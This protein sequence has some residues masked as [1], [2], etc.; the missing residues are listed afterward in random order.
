MPEFVVAEELT[1]TGSM[2]META[3]LFGDP[4]VF[5]QLEIRQSL[6]RIPEVS[7]KIREAQSF[8][9]TEDGG[10]VD[11]FQLFHISEEDFKV[12]RQVRTF[13]L[14]LVQIALF[15]RFKTRHGYPRLLVVPKEHNLVLKV[16]IQQIG[17]EE[18][19]DKRLRLFKL[20]VPVVERFQTA[21]TA[22]F[23]LVVEALNQNGKVNFEQAQVEAESLTQLIEDLSEKYDTERLVHVGP[24]RAGLKIFWK[25][26]FLRRF[27]FLDSIEVDPMLNWFWT[28]QLRVTALS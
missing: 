12:K 26:A 4:Q 6:I 28:P 10:S 7:L 25:E 9:D 24:G 11:L 5:D 13:L 20:Q 23:Y 15:E 22:Q 19:L 2:G 1:L 8:L 21:E 27:Q 17:M 18:Y 3:V 16:I 14:E